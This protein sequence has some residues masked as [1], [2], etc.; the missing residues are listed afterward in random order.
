M[1]RN[2]KKYR[3][4]YNGRKVKTYQYVLYRI[5]II[6]INVKKSITKV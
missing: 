1:Y 3:N 4:V 5:E 6:I 2:I